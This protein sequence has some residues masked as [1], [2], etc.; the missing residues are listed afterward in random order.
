MSNEQMSTLVQFS[1]ILVMAA[2]FYFMVWRPQRKEQAARQKLLASLKAGDKVYTVGGLYGT[3]DSLTEKT[4]VLE[5]ADGVKVTF[6]RNA[7]S[8]VREE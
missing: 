8:G 2:V 3:V 4:V 6:M 7:V 5:V 1:P